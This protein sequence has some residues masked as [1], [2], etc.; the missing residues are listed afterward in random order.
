LNEFQEYIAEEYVDHYKEGE[1]SRRGMLRRVAYLTGGAVMAVGFLRGLGID[2]TADEVLAAGPDATPAS[3]G[4]AL[5]VQPDDPA[6]RAGWIIYQGMDGAPLIGYLARP[7]GVGE[8][9]PGVL[10]VHENR[11]PTE[12]HQDVARR[13]AKQGFVALLPDLVSRDGGYGAIVDAAQIPALG[14][15]NT[16]RNVSDLRAAVATLMARPEVKPGG[17]GAV[18]YCFGGGMVWRTIMQEPNIV[19][20]V[21]YYGPTP[22]DLSGAPNIRA[23]VLAFYGGLDTRVTEGWPQMEDALKTAGVQYQAIVEPNAGH[24]FFNDTGQSYNAEAAADAWPRTLDFFRRN[25]PA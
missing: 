2:V 13:F 9:Y 25:L 3:E 10:H 23:N 7:A 20:A 12:H 6:I 8:Q 24:A 14:S 16:D 18:G 17:V 1:I 21:P 4:N 11:G 15:A 5:T 19:G 22:Q